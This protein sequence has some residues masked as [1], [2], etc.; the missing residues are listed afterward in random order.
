MNSSCGELYITYEDCKNTQA[1]EWITLIVDNEGSVCLAMLY[2]F[3]IFVKPIS[4]AMG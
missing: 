4:S 2:F 3:K 1:G